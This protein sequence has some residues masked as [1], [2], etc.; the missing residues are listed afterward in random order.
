MQPCSLSLSLCVC[1][2][3]HRSAHALTDLSLLP[4]SSVRPSRDT[5]TDR[6]ILVCPSSVCS[7]TLLRTFQIQAALSQL[8][9]EA[10]RSP[11]PHKSPRLCVLPKC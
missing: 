10:T 7:H 3:R 6:T 4:D 11:P 9:P 5:A 8:L 2:A 1:V